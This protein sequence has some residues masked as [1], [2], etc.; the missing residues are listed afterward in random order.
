MK[1]VNLIPVEQRRGGVGTAGRSGSGVYLLLGALGV[2]VIALATYVL[3]VNSIN[4]R[5]GQLTQVTAQADRVEAQAAAL[6]PYRDFATLRQQRIATVSAL[7]QSRFD[8]ERT[9]RQL[10]RVLP[11]DVSLN[12]FTGTVAPGVNV[13]GSGSASGGGSSVRGAVNAPAIE[14]VGCA[15]A[16]SDVSRV[17]SRLRRMSGVTRLALSSSEKPDATTAA[18]PAPSSTSGGGGPTDCATGDASR[19]KFDITVF[20]A[21]LPGAPAA[22]GPG[23]AT[24]GAPPAGT[25]APAAAGSSG[26][27]SASNPPAAK[28]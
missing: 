25:P 28:P 4:D 12:S 27:Q 9:M 5:K 14:L 16:Q 26:A 3:V 23:G 15:G 10:A 13:G 22:T 19:P 6:K 11:A 21:P 20:F 8:W 1:A 17:M 2:V 24:P 18:T 7:A